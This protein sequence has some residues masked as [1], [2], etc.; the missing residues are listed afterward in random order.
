MAGTLTLKSGD[1]WSL[2]FTFDDSSGVD[3]DITGYTAKFY[4]K[5][6]L[7][8]TNAQAI[9]GTSW[10]THSAPTT[11]VTTLTVSEDTTKAI[12]PGNYV[13]QVRLVL[14]G[15]VS[16]SDSGVCIIEEN[17]IDDET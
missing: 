17:L 9:Y 1:T 13:W 10:T 7:G 6:K 5:N 4:I 3:V 16:S 11:G 12:A 14:A 15:V 8:D 2:T